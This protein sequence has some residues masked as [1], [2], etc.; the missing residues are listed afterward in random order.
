MTH[1][2]VEERQKLGERRRAMNAGSG[3]EERLVRGPDGWRL[4]YW[5]GR[6]KLGTLPVI[7]I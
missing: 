7:P 1:L 2:T 3:V 6:K 5:H 4:E